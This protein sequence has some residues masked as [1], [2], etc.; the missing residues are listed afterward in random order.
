MKDIFLKYYQLG[1]LYFTFLIDVKSQ[2]QEVKLTEIASGLF[3]PTN[4]ASMGDG[5]LFVSQLDG[6]IKIVENDTI[7]LTPFF[8]YF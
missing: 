2:N 5:C 6:K 7:L 1:L 3:H 4:I 8:G